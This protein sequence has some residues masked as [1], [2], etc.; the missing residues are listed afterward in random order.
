MP[1]PIPALLALR[2]CSSAPPLECYGI[3]P[4][5]PYHTPRFWSGPTFPF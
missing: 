3:R 2:R 5:E 4:A 1:R